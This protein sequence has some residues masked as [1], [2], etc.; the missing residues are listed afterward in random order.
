MDCH[1]CA[2][3]Y[4]L[5]PWSQTP[6]RA[7]AVFCL[8]SNSEQARYRTGN[9]RVN[10]MLKSMA[11]LLLLLAVVV[12][13]VPLRSCCRLSHS[14][15]LSGIFQ[16][17]FHHFHRARTCGG[18]AYVIGHVRETGH[19][20]LEEDPELRRLIRTHLHKVIC[21]QVRDGVRE[22]LCVLVDEWA[23]AAASRLLLWIW[24]PGRRF[25]RRSAAARLFLLS[26]I[27]SLKHKGKKSC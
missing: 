1:C 2:W 9:S 13:V 11:V 4:P 24:F 15:T 22:R 12:H 18:E 21:A 19:L 16:V 20:L 25:P 3:W 23:A 8:F 14:Y 27:L 10:D 17:T 6:P 26:V 5:C 7:S